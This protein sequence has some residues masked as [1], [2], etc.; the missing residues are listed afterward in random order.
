MRPALRLILST[1]PP[2]QTGG[3]PPGLP[4]LRCRKRLPSRGL[5]YRP[6]VKELDAE[7]GLYYYGARYLDPKTSR[8]LSGDP[9][10]GE[11]IPSAPVNDEARKQNQNLPGQGGIFN[12]VNL[13]VYHYAGN[14]PVKYTDPDGVE[15]RVPNENDREQIK[16]MINSVSRY[17][18]E[19]DSRGNLHRLGYIRNWHTP[20]FDRRSQSFSD[21]LDE[22]IDSSLQITIVIGETAIVDGESVNVQQRYE[23]GVTGKTTISTEEGELRRSEVII[24]GRS[25][26]AQAIPLKN[27]GRTRDSAARTLVHEL[28]VHA[29]PFINNKL[30]SLDNENYVRQEMKWPERVPDE[31]HNN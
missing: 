9:A 18:Y 5:R 12:H 6:V 24:T 22:G 15:I 27:G 30:E 13:H 20:L 21:Q 7:T 29:I 28:T 19:I 3:K 16:R 23:G 26:S 2:A 31:R 14:N 10:M 25:T 17:K 4:A 1:S 11:Y 8:W